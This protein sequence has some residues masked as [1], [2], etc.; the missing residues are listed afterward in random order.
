MNLSSFTFGAHAIVHTDEA[1][2]LPSAVT[3]QL[4]ATLDIWQAA[5]PYEATFAAREYGVPSII[6]RFDGAL[7]E[8]GVFHAYEIQ[9]GCAWIGYAGVI[10]PE[11]ASARDMLARDA[12]PPFK[13]LSPREP[14]HDDDLWLARATLDEARADAGNLMIRRW[15]M[16]GLSE[17]ERTSLLARSMKPVFVHCS[18]S[19]GETLGWWK[20]VTEPD[21]DSFPWSDGFA[22]KPLKSHGSADVVIWQPDARSGGATRSQV[23]ATLQKRGAMYLQKLVSPQK[24][25]LG[26]K[27]FHRI[28]RPFFGFDPRSRAWAP[29]HG[30]WTARPAPAMRIHGASDAV[31]G[32]LFMEQ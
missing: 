13:L 3:R 25:M 17:D 22:L 16:E 10:N 11:F 5:F 32:P 26:E 14:L 4:I 24:T 12:W 20:R 2:V 15:L 6:V 21:I 8:D 30:V 1:L 19:Y 9:E 23:R 7:D 31:S 28:L 18:K 27:P 29:L